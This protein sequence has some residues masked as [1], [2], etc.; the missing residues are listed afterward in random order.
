MVLGLGAAACGNSSS[1]TPATDANIVFLDAPIPDAP[2]PDAY[3]CNMTD[4]GN[5]QCVDLNTDPLHCGSCDKACTMGQECVSQECVCPEVSAPGSPSILFSQFFMQM[6]ATGALGVFGAGSTTDGVVVAYDPSTQQ[7]G[8][9]A[10]LG[11]LSVPAVLYGYN[12]DIGSQQFQMA[13]AATAGTI[14]FDYA[15]ADG[16]SATVTDAT[17]SQV[18]DITNPQI[19]ADG[20]SF[21]VASMTI[22]IGSNCS[23]S[24][25]AGVTGDAGVS[26]AAAP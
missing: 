11:G 17:F 8:V 20:C 23:A 25:D 1:G 13:F 26:D 4:C 19:V 7:T 22:A 14:N 5:N 12:V 10:S 9:D 18:G 2:T 16:V 24:M 15:C 21:N 6:G 3:I